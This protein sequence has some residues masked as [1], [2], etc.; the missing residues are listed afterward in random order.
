MKKYDSVIFDLDGTLWDTCHACAVGWNNVLDRHRIQ[1]RAISSEDIRKV[2]G[3]P[4]EE[5][6]RSVFQGLDE[7][8][9]KILIHETML[10]DNRVIAQ[11]GGD[12]FPGVREGLAVLAGK[13]PL[14]IVS[15]CQA[16]YIETFLSWSGLSGLFKDHE[17][18]G[19]TGLGKTENLD[20]LMKRNGL[21][22]P[23]LVGDAPGDQKAAKECGV[24]FIFAEY[25][26]G[27][28]PAPNGSVKK[29]EELLNL[30]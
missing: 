1:F 30:L 25:G 2:T 6:V 11:M 9:L 10:E 4:H 18:W 17:C 28:C 3:R 8:E 7:E 13:Y 12:L 21:R 20:R 26:F 24:P 19:N 29:F 23:V 22:C 16:G 14:F 5:C 27:H 15:N